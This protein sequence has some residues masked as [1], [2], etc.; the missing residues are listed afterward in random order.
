MF[1]RKTTAYFF[2]D[3]VEIISRSD[4]SKLLTQTKKQHFSKVKHCFFMSLM[5]EK[6]A[7]KV[8]LYVKNRGKYLFFMIGFLFLQVDSI[9]FRTRV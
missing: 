6:A 8:L 2:G 3:P 9:F 7:F 4:G 5:Y 1:S